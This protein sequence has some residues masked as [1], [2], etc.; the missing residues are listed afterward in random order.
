MASKEDIVAPLGGPAVVPSE[1]SD[2]EEEEEEEEEEKDMYACK[3]GRRVTCNGCGLYFCRRNGYAYCYDGE[4][5]HGICPRCI[6]QGVKFICDLPECQCGYTD[7][8][9]AGG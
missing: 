5:E 8:G 3:C 7:G 2:E 1:D 9:E 4:D 6:A